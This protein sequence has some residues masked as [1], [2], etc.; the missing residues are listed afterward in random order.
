MASSRGLSG[1]ALGITAAGGLLAYSGVT[2]KG[3]AGQLRS[4]IAGGSPSAASQTQPITFSAGSGG[5][6]TDAAGA[7]QLDAAN[8]GG[9]TYA[10]FWTAVMGNLG[11]PA[12]LG[13]LEAMAGISNFE[14]LNSYFNPMNIEWHPGDN[15]IIQGTGNFNNVGVQTYSGIDEGV[16]A[17]SAFLLEPHW[18]GVL[19][20]L[21]TGNFQLVNAAIKQA[22]TW[23]AYQAPDQATTDRI[24]ATSMGQGSVAA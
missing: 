10:S 7:V 5:A 12:T 2:G 24:L 19:T 11:R 22:Y 9:G 18:S 16:A 20:A 21:A 15:P 23:A 6:T 1:I 4:L 8:I 17:T 13:N 14:G 3:F